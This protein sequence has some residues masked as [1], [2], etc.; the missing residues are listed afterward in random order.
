MSGKRTP[1]RSK[2]PRDRTDWKRVRA[3]TDDDIGRAVAED[4]D[5]APLLDDAWIRRAKLVPPD[6]KVPVSI[7]LDRD[8]LEWFKRRGTRYQ[9]R[10]NAVL[11]AYVE[12]HR[13]SSRDS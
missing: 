5:A 12:A 7:R 6:P 8:V 1:R 11:R 3:Q 9:T 2:P 13:T 10:I 4:P